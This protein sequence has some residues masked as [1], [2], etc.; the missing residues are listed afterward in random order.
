MFTSSRQTSGMGA[1]LAYTAALRTGVAYLAARRR[2]HSQ[3][4]RLLQNACGDTDVHPV[5]LKIL[6]KSIS[7]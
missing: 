3:N 1:F 5:R 2:G 4:I 7:L 6:D